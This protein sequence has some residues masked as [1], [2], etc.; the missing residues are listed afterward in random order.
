MT[1]RRGDGGV[2]CTRSAE[3]RSLKRVESRIPLVEK[4]VSDLAKKVNSIQAGL[5]KCQREVQHRVLFKGESCKGPNQASTE[6]DLN[7]N[8]PNPFL[9]T[10]SP[11]GWRNPQF[12]SVSP[13][14]PENS[15]YQAFETGMVS[16][17]GNVPP[18]SCPQFDG[19]NPQMWRD[20]CEIFFDVYG[21]HPANWV[22]VALLNF[23]GN[24]S[25]WLQSV[26]H[27]LV[28]ISWL[29]LC[30]WVCLK[31]T[32]DRQ[33]LLIRQWFHVGQTSSVAEYVERF[34]GLMHQL[35]S[36]DN[37][38]TPLYFLTKFVDGLKDEIR[39]VVM[40]QKAVDL[41]AACSVALLQEE[42]LE[43][44]KRT[45]Y[46]KTAGSNF[47]KV[48][49]RTAQV[50]VIP[51]SPATSPGEERKCLESVRTNTR[52]DKISALKSYRRSK[53]LCFTCGKRWSKDH[54]CA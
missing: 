6:E 14:T 22:K 48:F 18:M 16:I 30:D 35:L 33:E 15:S 54:K 41:D 2:G 4:K 21:V 36:Y 28:G 5:E 44:G 47:N 26:R 8:S 49:S 7:G 46:R 38:L 52:N 24:A 17:G 50:N 32:R 45:T 29:E 23:T 11:H 51:K 31:F 53:G 25:F 19:E 20:N 10:P 27:Q 34:D 9:F 12:N 43:G 40:L 39:G 37:A 42:I 13:F 3:L 1:R